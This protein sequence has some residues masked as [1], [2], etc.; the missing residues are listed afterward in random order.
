MLDVLTIAE[1]GL[2]IKLGILVF[3]DVPSSSDQLRGKSR[4]SFKVCPVMTLSAKRRLRFRRDSPVF[5]HARWI[6]PQWVI[7]DPSSAN[8]DGIGETV[9]TAI[10]VTTIVV[11]RNVNEIVEDSRDTAFVS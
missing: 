4:L 2:L 7:E 3:E 8:P 6:S 11:V 10:I 9:D 5:L 1:E